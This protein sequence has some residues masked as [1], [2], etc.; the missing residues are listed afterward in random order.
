MKMNYPNVLFIGIGG[1]GMSA[2]ARYFLSLGRKV[3]GYDKTPSG[4]IDQLVNEGA[5]IV[6]ED[7][8]LDLFHPLNPDNCLVVLTPAVPN[9][10]CLVEKVKSDGFKVLKRAEVL[11]E[12]TRSTKSIG[13]AGTHGKS[14]TSAMLAFLL[15]QTDEGCNAFLGAIA[16]NFNS[17]FLVKPNAPLTVMEADEFDRSFLHLSPFA[18]IITTTDPDHLDI[19]GSEDKFAEGFRQYAMK[20]HPNGFLVMREGIALT[21]I[22]RKI[23]YA[24]DSPTSD[25]TAY[26]LKETDQGVSFSLKTPRAVYHEVKVGINGRHNAENALAA[27][28]VCAEMGLDL[29]S[30]IATFKNFLGIKRR[31]EI[32]Y[33]S[34][35]LVYIDDYAHHPTEIN[36]L[37]IAVKAMFPGQTITGIFQPHLFSR[38]KDFAEGFSEE[39]AKLDRVLLLPI[40]PAR[41]QPIL[42]ID[43]AW[44]MAKIKH[45]RK[46][47][48]APGEL[49]NRLRNVDRGIL[50]TIGAGDID[51]FVGPIYEL[52]KANE[53]Q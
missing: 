32:V 4:L 17:N 15:S 3:Y 35:Q 13:V 37:I 34:P 52:L 2:L 11:G 27:L 50:L 6:F 7:E 41:E 29:S 43:S 30:C 9:N 21:S 19:Y 22:C 40:Y 12:I 24:L 46:E 18:S 14:T 31:F 20:L 38:T 39:L 5:K 33:K 8:W 44:L 23:T 51:R 25:Y 47:L 42:G 10:A 45:N 36:R 16:T 53:T 1:I 48:V 49:L 28:A 26:D